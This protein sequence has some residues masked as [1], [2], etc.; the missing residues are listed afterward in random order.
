MSQNPFC[1]RDPLCHPVSSRLSVHL[2]PPCPITLFCSIWRLFRR[3]RWTCRSSSPKAAEK[4]CWRRRD[5]SV[6]WQ[7]NTACSPIRRATSTRRYERGGSV[8]QKGDHRPIVGTSVHTVSLSLSLLFPGQRDAGS[9]APQLAGKVHRRHQSARHGDNHDRGAVHHSRS[10]RTPQQGEYQLP[11]TDPW[12][13]E[14]LRV[15]DYTKSGT[16]ML[17]RLRIL[18]HRIHLLSF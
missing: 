16:R 5:A 15:K 13:C 2:T 8:W 6:S 10:R 4:P 11:S 9:E 12:C 7:T 14:T 1:L 3:A 18:H 17:D